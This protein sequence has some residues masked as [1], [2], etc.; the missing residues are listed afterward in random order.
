MK[1]GIT[2]VTLLIT[3]IVMIVLSTTVVVSGVSAM[4]NAKKMKFAAELVFMQDTVQNYMRTHENS[5]P[6]KGGVV[7]VQNLP[8][9][10]YYEIDMSLLGLIDTAYGNKLNA[11]EKDIYV[12][13]KTNNE[14]YYLKGLKIGNT[15][16]YNLTDEL[17]ESINYTDTNAV[18]KDG[19]IFNQSK[20]D[21]TNSDISVNVQVPKE[22]SNV[23]VVSG[24]T[25]ITEFAIEGK[26][27]VFTISEAS[28]FNIAVLYTKDGAQLQQTH[29]VSN[30][31]NV[32]PTIE[33]KEKIKITSDNKEKTSITINTTDDL[34][35]VDKVLYTTDKVEK[36]YFETENK[37]K[38][39]TNNN[40]VVDKFTKYVT[41]Y[42]VDKAGNSKILVETL[43]A[44]ATEND[45]AKYGLI[46]HYDAIN[47]TG[48]GHS[49]TTTVW[50]DLSGNGNNGTLTNF[51][52]TTSSGWNGKGILLDGVNDYIE[53][54]DVVDYKETNAITIQFVDL[55]GIL[56]SNRNKGKI[57]VIAESSRDFNTNTNS[58]L[59]AAFERYTNGMSA[60]VQFDNYYVKNYKETVNEKNT[61]YTYI[62]DLK[63]KTNPNIKIYR[64]TELLHEEDEILRGS[65]YDYFKNY[66][67]FIGSR[68]GS[69]LFANLKIG[70]FKIYNRALTEDEIE[71]NYKVDKIRFGI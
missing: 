13:S 18:S 50:K 34:S 43:D 63:N 60:A 52:N 28:N 33:I 16:Y 24:N 1:K 64:D 32:A 46:L 3:L 27:I 30:F 4:N 10:E 31:D 65:F 12:V 5:L 8:Q 53:T 15:I 47:N 48:N 35:G 71:Q 42:V 6:I 14:V 57:Y 19:I 55:D 59:V 69:D 29:S 23:T 56:Y 44:T 2:L 26:Y 58:F 62:I 7:A 54:I 25:E 66:E 11:D 21:Y 40:V 70:N 49:N 67:L 36:T 20:T 37:G 68:R 45:Y 41:F 9:G 39:V 17:K 38:Q 22:Y 51:N 61:L